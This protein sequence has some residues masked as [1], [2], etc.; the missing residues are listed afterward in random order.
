MSAV[1]R[2]RT[3]AACGGPF[4]AGERTGLET[5]VAGGILY[6]AVHS[7]HSTYPPRRES[8]AAHRLATARAA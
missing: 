7:H 8:E 1:E 5:V 2:Q 4:E 3:C 6:V